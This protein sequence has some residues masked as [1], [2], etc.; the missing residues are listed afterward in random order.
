M[1]I[2]AKWNRIILMIFSLIEKQQEIKYKKKELD[3][4][5]FAKKKK[6]EK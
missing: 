4:L 3:I 2:K 5:T 6:N 1:S